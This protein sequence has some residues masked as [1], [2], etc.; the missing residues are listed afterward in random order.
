M[1]QQNWGRFTVRGTEAVEERIT[2][3]VHTIADTVAAAFSRDEYQALIMIGGYGR[4]EGGVVVRDGVEYPHNNFDLVLI[5]RNLAS[6]AIPAAKEKLNAVLKPVV[7]TIGI[8]IDVSVIN[9]ATLRSASCRVIWYD[10]RFGHKTLLGDANLVPSLTRFTIPRI[11]SWDARNLLV[12]RG[13]LMIINDLLLEKPQRTPQEHKLIVKHIVKAVI[14]YGDTLLYFLD[15]YS[16]SYVEKQKHMRARTDVDPEFKAIYEEAMNF[17]FQPDYQG[18]M[19]RDLA[20]WI[21]QLR[22]HFEQ[23]FLLCESK[24]LKKAIPS[25]DAYPHLAFAHALG[26]ELPAIKPFAK[27]LLA[28]RR[29]QPYPG[30]G[31]LAAKLG[32][33]TLTPAGILPIFFPLIAYQLKSEE[34]R[35]MAAQHLQA[36]S[37]EFAAL[38]RAYLRAWGTYGDVNFSNTLEKYNISLEEEV[39]Q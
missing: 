7:E 17:R 1:L 24:R 10:M 37:T 20:Q 27:K 8:G 28:L 2:Q 34:F 35:T 29:N 11:P 21:P 19:A 4:G 16:W 22:S 6:A 14:G 25:W 5:T 12:N 26:D 23:V 33:K 3:M 15:D 9:A 38:R 36:S 13:T 30:K 18:F 32:F 39:R 31:P